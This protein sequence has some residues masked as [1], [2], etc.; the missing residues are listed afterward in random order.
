MITSGIFLIA[1]KPKI[2]QILGA[3]MQQC[4]V[5][6]QVAGFCESDNETSV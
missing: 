2:P 1:V 4:S 6:W 5:S 3:V